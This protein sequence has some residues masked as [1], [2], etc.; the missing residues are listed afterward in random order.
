MIVADFIIEYL[1]ARGVKRSY[2]YPGSLA[3]FIM[4]A[5]RKRSGEID[6]RLLY[7]E[8]ACGFAAIGDSLV[9]G[10][11]ALCWA[12][13]GP[14]A[15]NLV[16]PIANAWLDS[17]PVIFLTA[18]VHTADSREKLGCAALRQNGNQELDIIQIAQSIVK[19]AARIDDPNAVKATLDS[20]WEAATSGRKGP[21]LIDLPI[22]ISRSEIG[23]DG[24]SFG[25]AFTPRR[26]ASANGALRAIEAEIAAANKPLI[27]AGGGIRSAQVEE[28]FLAWLD[29]LSARTPNLKVVVTLRGKDLLASDN[30]LNFGVAGVWG[31]ES[32][33]EA[34][35]NADLI[36]TIGSRLANRQLAALGGKLPC[37][38]IRVDIDAAE[39][40]RSVTDAE[41]I[42]MRADLSNLFE[43]NATK[44][45]K[46]VIV[47]DVGQNM[48]RVAR[49]FA[50]ES[51]DRALFSAG[52]GA[53]G[54]S[55]CAAIGAHYAA[56]NAEIIAFCGDGG[57][58]MSVEELHFIARRRVPIALIV[59]NNNALGLIRAFQERNFNGEYFSVTADTGYAS[60]DWEALAKAYGVNYVL[61]DGD[62]DALEDKGR[63]RA[64]MELASRLRKTSALPLM[65]EARV[66]PAYP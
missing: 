12:I 45:P 60:P 31:N 18:N 15:G 41:A 59:F 6:N 7:T 5:L 11:V 38:V 61:F 34:A 24:G 37:K 10:D 48:W 8:Q 52:L 9:S 29:K 50:I 39:F 21:V 63:L 30:P 66:K 65:I 20:A 62:L 16:T 36:I 2:G 32:A 1:I 54:F 23:F 51:G 64:L 28:S 44:P 56:P 46:R 4:E 53:M 43:P 25:S 35:K 55:L 47:S 17:V 3:G 27:V 40:A 42:D 14:G 57:L 26:A 19:F 58:Q 22:D 49:E 13:S 33:N